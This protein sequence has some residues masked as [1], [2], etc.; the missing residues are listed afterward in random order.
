MTGRAVVRAL[1]GAG[2]EVIGLSFSR[3][4]PGLT[5]LDLRD[6]DA[7][8]ALF[9]D[10]QP[11]TAVVHCAAERRPDV[12]ETDLEHTQIMNGRDIPLPR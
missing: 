9:K 4:G 12:C 10:V 11:V 3:E 1:R 6:A 2:T 8:S 7:V 5:K